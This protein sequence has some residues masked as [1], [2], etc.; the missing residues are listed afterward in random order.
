[1]L[2]ELEETVDPTLS[3][4]DKTVVGTYSTAASNAFISFYS[5]LTSP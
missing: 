4:D 2:S 5:S 1:L 3:I